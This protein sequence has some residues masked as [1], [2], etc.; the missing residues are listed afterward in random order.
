MQTKL[1][2]MGQSAQ[3]LEKYYKRLFYN[4]KIFLHRYGYS[5]TYK[6]M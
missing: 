6:N 1:H 3:N 4:N 5:N 2:G